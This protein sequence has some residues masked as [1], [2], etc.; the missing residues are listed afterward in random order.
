MLQGIQTRAPD[1]R[2]LLV[3]YPDIL[4]VTGHG[5]WPLVP[6]AFGDVPYLRGIE[7]DLNQ[8]LARTADLAGLPLP[9][10][11]AR[12]TDHGPAGGSRPQQLTATSRSGR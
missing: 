12:G 2:V 1:A 3:G 4:P 11:P 5:C 7:V 9:P 10:E 8:M 6:F